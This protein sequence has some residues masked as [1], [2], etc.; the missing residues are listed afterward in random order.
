MKICF[1][2][3]TPFPPREGIASHVWGLAQ[4]LD[5]ERHQVII[6]TRR[7]PGSH[8]MDRY[9]KI[10]VLRP[11][12]L[13]I[14]PFHVHLHGI[15][16]SLAL[17]RLGEGVD[18]IHYHSPLPAPVDAP[19]PALTT[20]HSMVSADVHKRKRNSP[21]EWAIWAQS[22]ISFQIERRLEEASQELTAVSDATAKD[23]RGLFPDLRKSVT[24][25]P[26]GID[27]DYFTP[28]AHP[29]GGTDFLLFVGR[30]DQ[31]KGIL[32]L[33]KAMQLVWEKNPG[34]GLKVVGSGPLESTVR[35][36]AD[37][38]RWRGK[39]E[40]LG[41]LGPR[42]LRDLYR[43]GL[44]LV[45]PS[46]YESGPR[47]ALESMSCGTPVIGTPVGLMA[48]LVVDGQTGFVIPVHAPD[49]LAEKIELLRGS[50][51]L[52]KQMSAACRPSILQG[53]SLKT[54]GERYLQIYTRIL[55]GQP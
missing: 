38:M 16:V 6:L 26:N 43:N 47:V 21:Y 48:D 24:T 19:I 30:L 33:L 5:R 4:Y 44:A 53:Y 28:G 37:E 3:S 39:V 34:L 17:S 7:V 1:I 10:L 11:A 49:A 52:R 15:F 41:Q 18:L 27:T 13:P 36:F 20:F 22:K 54:M 12:F 8:S 9:G 55:A 35:E 29:T 23:L 50:K 40:L 2:C 14:Y 32:D 31:G 25:I 45:C 46:L 51:T 42:E